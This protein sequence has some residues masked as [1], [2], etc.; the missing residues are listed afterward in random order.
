MDFHVF[1]KK[2]KYKAVFQVQSG[3]EQY[4]TTSMLSGAIIPETFSTK[5]NCIL[6]VIIKN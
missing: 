5:Y 3:R 2:K 4:T 6:S 1:K